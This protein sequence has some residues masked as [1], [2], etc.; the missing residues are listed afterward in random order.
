MTLGTKILSLISVMLLAI[1]AL[2]FLSFDSVLPKIIVFISACYMS[3]VAYRTK[4]RMWLLFFVV[5]AIV[6]IPYLRFFDFSDIAWRVLDVIAMAGFIFFIYRYYDGYRKGDA[7]ESF[8]SSLF[9][10]EEWKIED[11]TKDMSR[12]LGREVESDRHPDLT[13]RSLKTGKRMAIEC[14]FRSKFWETKEGTGIFWD[15]SNHDTYKAYGGREKID[16][17]VAF[18]LGG[19]AKSPNKL[20]LVP[21]RMLEEYKGKIVPAQYLQK[22]EKGVKAPLSLDGPQ[23]KI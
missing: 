3:V 10:K 8:V 2:G 20:F 12:H 7:F 23:M 4:E 5:T 22:F 18:G 13:L 15:E 14:K 19:N 16:V 21:L 6:F 17:T 11:W 1:L 9:P